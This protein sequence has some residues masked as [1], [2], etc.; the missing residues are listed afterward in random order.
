VKFSFLV[1]SSTR[2]YSTTARTIRFFRSGDR[3][4]RAGRF[5]SASQRP[6]LFSPSSENLLTSRSISR[7]SV[8]TV[9]LVELVVPVPR[10]LGGDQSTVRVKLV[11]LFEGAQPFVLDLF[12][13]ACERLSTA[14]VLISR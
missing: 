1:V 7:S 4:D 13:R 3:K 12:E 8:L 6:E 14:V 5:G 2:S 10:E 9:D 11:V